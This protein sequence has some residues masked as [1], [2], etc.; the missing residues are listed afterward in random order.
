MPSL[1]NI[2]KCPASH[3][4]AQLKG[5]EFQS[6]S[7]NS[8]HGALKLRSYKLRWGQGARV[9]SN[10][11]DCQPE[12]RPS[13]ARKAANLAKWLRV[14]YFLENYSH[15]PAWRLDS[16]ELLSQSSGGNSYSSSGGPQIAHNRN[17]TR[18]LNTP[19]TI[20]RTS[21]EAIAGIPNLR[22]KITT[23]LP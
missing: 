19:S 3:L 7:K 9:S 1:E 15:Q 10:P 8:I 21:R 17:V 13:L 11:D 20:P 23:I 22:G 2:E 14:L 16:V 18:C 5:F 4:P 6:N 12:D